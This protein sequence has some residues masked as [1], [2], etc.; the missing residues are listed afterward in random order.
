MEEN[1]TRR[2]PETKTVKKLKKEMKKQETEYFASMQK[3]M[4]NLDAMKA[5]VKI[6]TL[7]MLNLVFPK[8]FSTIGGPR[9]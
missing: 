9:D 2:E 7:L 4:S 8:V 1:P 6:T 5:Q 3:Y